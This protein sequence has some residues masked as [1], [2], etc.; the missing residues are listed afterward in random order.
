MF[1]VGASLLWAFA[2]LW[3]GLTGAANPP[4]AQGWLAWLVSLA[5]SLVCHQRPERSFHLAS[6]PFPVCARCTGIY[7]GSACV[8]VRALRSQLG[9][10]NVFGSPGALL[11]ASGVP[12]AATLSYE[13][14]TGLVPSNA[15]RAATGL[16]LGVVVTFLIVALLDSEADE[17]SP[18]WGSE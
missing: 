7:L 8:A 10:V 14:L 2:L 15:V 17:S 4:N 1:V 18:A 3:V 13:W 6:I 9:P 11:G 5:G 12:A 16:P